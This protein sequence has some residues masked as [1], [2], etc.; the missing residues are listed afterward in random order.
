MLRAIIKTKSG[1]L[2]IAVVSALLWMPE[3]S[4][5]DREVALDVINGSEFLPIQMTVEL[6]VGDNVDVTNMIQGMMAVDKFQGGLLNSG[7]GCAQR[8]GLL[9]MR[10]GSRQVFGTRVG[11]KYRVDVSPK[12]ETVGSILDQEFMGYRRVYSTARYS[13]IVHRVTGIK[14]LGTTEVD[15]LFETIP[16]EVS[17]F[18]RC[19]H[20]NIDSVR[21]QMTSE[22]RA[23]LGLYDD[24]WRVESVQVKN[25]SNNWVEQVPPRD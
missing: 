2:A 12:G 3:A 17:E 16:G 20:P 18:G 21:S 9:E 15:V 6:P 8:M 11:S 19:V 22:A 1:V 23:R 13:L 5:L 14:S 4:A 10:G 24:G 7:Y 25:S